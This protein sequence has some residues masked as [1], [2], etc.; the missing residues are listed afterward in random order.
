MRPMPN[1]VGQASIGTKSAL[2]LKLVMCGGQSDIMI[3][4]E[5]Q[6]AFALTLKIPGF[7][8]HTGS[9]LI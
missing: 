2:S 9:V 7:K 6:V 1:S 5:Q 3:Q 8:I 4:H